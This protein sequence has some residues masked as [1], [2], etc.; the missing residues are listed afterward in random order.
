ML[1]N[2]RLDGVELMGNPMN[3]AARRAEPVLAAIAKRTGC[4][5]TYG[6]DGHREQD[7]ENFVN[8][9]SVA[10]K[11][12]GQTARLVGRVKPNLSWSRL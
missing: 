3:N 6:I 1:R 5:T 10:S 12:I 8:D 7:I 9:P 11:S 2:G 4:L